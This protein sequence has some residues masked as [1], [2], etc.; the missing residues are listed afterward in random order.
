MQKHL[1]KIRETKVILDIP[2]ESGPG[3]SLAASWWILIRGIP[4]SYRTK[5]SG[6]LG[7][8]DPDTLIRT[9]EKH[10]PFQVPHF[11]TMSKPSK[12]K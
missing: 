6:Y 5:I 2:E 10:D 4:I 9:L 1:D 7:Q 8:V 3:S 11:N 12:P